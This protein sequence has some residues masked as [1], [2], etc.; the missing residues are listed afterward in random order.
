MAAISLDDVWVE[1]ALR[2][3][4]KGRGAS[5]PLPARVGGALQR[6][7]GRISIAA[8]K[9]VTLAVGAGERVAV[10]GHNGSGKSTLLRTIGGIF[11]PT[12]G[13]VATSGRIATLFDPQ[14]A[15]IPEC[16]GREYAIL[17]GLYLGFARRTVEEQ[18]EGIAALSELG[19]YFDLPLSAY[20]SGMKLR[21]AFASCT[22]F[23][24]E[25]LLMDEMIGVVDERFLHKIEAQLAGFFAKAGI[26]MLASHSEPL[27]HAFCNRAILLDGGEVA[28]DG[29]VDGALRRYREAEAGK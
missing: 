25:I 17:R 29:D 9:Q 18:I 4:K 14:L 6:R 3:A 12:R 15:M 26:V 2:G 21:L 7:N 16:T 19:E 11:D 22:W 23:D 8:L 10:L 24:P 5:P 1:F 28:F 13:A 27:A 20:S